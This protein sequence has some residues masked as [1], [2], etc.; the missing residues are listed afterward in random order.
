MYRWDRLEYLKIL[1]NDKN[2]NDIIF[3]FKLVR[4][5]YMEKERLTEIGANA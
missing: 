3:G 1:L 5:A 2:N 4:G